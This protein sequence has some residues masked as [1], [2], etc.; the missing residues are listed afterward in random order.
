MALVFESVTD[1]I[2]GTPLFRLRTRGIAAPVYAKAEF[3]SVGGSVKDRAALAMV[4]AAERD[5]QLRPGGTIVEATSGNTGIGL[6]IVGRQRGYRV[7]A[8]V[9]DRSAQEK[10]DIL[11]AYGAEGSLWVRQAP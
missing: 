7:V 8:V 2:G 4:E 9:S 1:A 5:G 6:A 11:R 10:T 3:L